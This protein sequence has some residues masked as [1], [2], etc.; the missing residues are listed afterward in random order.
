[1]PA[2]PDIMKLAGTLEPSALSEQ[3]HGVLH[4]TGTNEAK[5]AR[6]AEILELQDDDGLAIHAKVRD[7]IRDVFDSI[8]RATILFL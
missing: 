4:S 5:E 7:S 8:G 3:W 6:I 2:T 1:M